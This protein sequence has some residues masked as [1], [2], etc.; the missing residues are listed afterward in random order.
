M[1]SI[2]VVMGFLVLAALMKFLSN[3]DVI[4]GWNLL[5]HDFYLSIWIAI[6]LLI[7]FYLLG[8][9][10]LALDSPIENIGV[11]RL[12]FS[13]LFFSLSIYLSIGLLGNNLGEIEAFLPSKV[14]TTTAS[15]IHTTLIPGDQN[16]SDLDNLRWYSNYSEALNNAKLENKNIFIDFNGFTCSNCKW[17]KAN[18]LSKPQIL[19]LLSRFI[20]VS[21]Y[22]DGQGTEFIKNRKMQEDRFGTIA[23]PFY[24]IMNRE[25]KVISYF[26]GLTRNMNEFETFLKKG[27]P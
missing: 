19:N 15:N 26:P 25:D 21:L 3:A 9:F 7:T 4:W 8:K 23:L 22:T 5:N 27:L 17:M 2:K 24:V 10:R 11:I 16:I 20:L 13:I 1:N 12:L 14:F 6:S 18:I